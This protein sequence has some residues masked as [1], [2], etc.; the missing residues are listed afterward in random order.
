[1]SPIIP[2]IVYMIFVFS[3][4]L[5]YSDSLIAKF[6]GSQA[7]LHCEQMAEKLVKNIKDRAIIIEKQSPNKIPDC[8]KTKGKFV[9][10]TDLS[11]YSVLK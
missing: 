3:Y 4:P 8:V 6:W 5:G 1:M 10:D 2:P 7:Q 9:C 11:K